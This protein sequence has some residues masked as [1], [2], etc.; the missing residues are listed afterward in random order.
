MRCSWHIRNNTPKSAAISIIKTPFPYVN[1]KVDL[2][3]CVIGED[4]PWNDV[5]PLLQSLADYPPIS[6]GELHG[7][8]S[9]LVL[10]L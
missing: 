1:R 10:K 9:L 7:I 4:F 2:I 3:L 5:V 8:H 6:P